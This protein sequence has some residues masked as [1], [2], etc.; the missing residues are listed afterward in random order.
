MLFRSFTID[1]P[2]ANVE[3]VEILFRDPLV[4]VNNPNS[5]ELLGRCTATIPTGNGAKT[6]NC[7]AFGA[8]IAQAIVIPIDKTG[9]VGF[10]ARGPVSP[11][12]R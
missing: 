3:S 5:D 7:A 10:A 9:N 2:D 12:G 6:V 8:V 11:P 1:D 4:N